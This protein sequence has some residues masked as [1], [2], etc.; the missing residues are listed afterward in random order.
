M[1]LINFVSMSDKLVNIIMLSAVEYAWN[2]FGDWFVVCRRSHSASLSVALLPR[3]LGFTCSLYSRL[4][5]RF[6][7]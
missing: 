5:H 7:S 4:P 1:R 2:F 3:T 6:R